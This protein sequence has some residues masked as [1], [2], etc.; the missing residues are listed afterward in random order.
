MS[1]RTG[2]TSTTTRVGNRPPVSSQLHATAI[3]EVAL[4]AAALVEERH[5]A[6]AALAAEDPRHPWQRVRE[7]AA[8]LRI[9]SGD[10]AR[11]LV[12]AA[13]ERALNGDRHVR[14]DELDPDAVAL[15][16]GLCVHLV[17]A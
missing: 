13:R 12:L 11:A 8:L 16:H 7:R 10:P 9:A 1:T 17:L 14:A 5:P 3:L 15:R 4:L 2:E 6:L